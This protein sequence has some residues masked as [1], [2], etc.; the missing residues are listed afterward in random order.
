[1]YDFVKK[2]EEALH[3][4]GFN[5]TIMVEAERKYRQAKVIAESRAPEQGAFWLIPSGNNWEIY[6]FFDSQYP[7]TDHAFIWPRYLAKLLMD[8]PSVQV[9]NAYAGL[10]RGRVVHL[11]SG[12]VIYHGGDIPGGN[13]GLQRVANEFNLPRGKWK[14]IFEEHEQMIPEHYR[15]IQKALKYQPVLAAPQEV[16]FDDDDY[17]D[18]WS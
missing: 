8:K 11:R 12:P 5:Q 3:L 10:P 14:A 9:R 17:D 15:I 4:H 7:Q 16:D 6:S 13:S 1:M 2:L 18:D